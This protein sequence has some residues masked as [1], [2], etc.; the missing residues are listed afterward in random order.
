MFG[1]LLPEPVEHY[2]SCSDHLNTLRYREPF[3]CSCLILYS[4]F[5]VFILLILVST[6]IGQSLGQGSHCERSRMWGEVITLK[7][8]QNCFFS[9]RV[10]IQ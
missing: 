5:S 10:A 9:L 8:A 4:Y 1:L 7:V 6:H 3:V 2:L